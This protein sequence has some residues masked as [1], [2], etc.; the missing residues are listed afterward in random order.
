MKLLHTSDWH[1]GKVLH[2]QSLI[3]DQRHAL[4]QIHDLLKEG[5]HDICIIAGDV[6][7]RSIPSVEA[8]ELLS[9]FL[10]ELRSFSQVPVVMIPGNHDSA[11]RLSFCAGVMAHQNI[12]IK[13]DPFSVSTPIT[14]KKDG[15]RC[16]IY[17]L[18]FLDPATYNDCS[19]ENEESV[20][21]GHETAIRKALELI[22]INNDS[23]N[24]N[25]LSGHLFTAGG[26]SSDSERTFV[27][28]SGL[29]DPS[30][31]QGFHYT[32]LGHLHRPQQVNDTT[33]YSGSL[34][35][36]SFSE[37]NDT[38]N[39]LSVEV[40][41]NSLKIEPNPITPLRDMARLKGTFKEFLTGQK[42]A[43][44]QQYYVEIELTD[45][46]LIV[47]PLAQLRQRFP[48]ILSVR[49]SPSQSLTTSRKIKSIDSRDSIEEDFIAFYEYLYDRAPEQNKKKLFSESIRTL[50]DETH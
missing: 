42:Y 46:A 41:G 47:N 20:K 44:C 27:G 48:Y 18:P 26:V 12:H 43:E 7:D 24:I 16:L 9:W 4:V 6:F 30:L 36:Y 29:V 11:G 45:T 10:T 25:I 28:T 22:N 13:T 8:V 31:F 37:S 3:E 34:L 5:S 39:V 1:L 21:A 40:T 38:K 17:A 19:N 2:E 23:N 50:T 15:E 49:Q 32:A 33:W 14:I 35:K